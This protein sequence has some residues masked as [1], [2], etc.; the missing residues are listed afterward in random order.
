MF[1]TGGTQSCQKQPRE[2]IAP[3][4]KALCIFPPES[5]SQFSKALFTMGHSF[6]YVLTA[7]CKAKRIPQWL[8]VLATEV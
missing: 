7:I 5:L 8:K 4:V 1:K 6:D 3:E 2:Q